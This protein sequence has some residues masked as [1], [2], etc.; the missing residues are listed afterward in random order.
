LVQKLETSERTPGCRAV[1]YDDLFDSRGKQVGR[2]VHVLRI[3]PGQHRQA[4]SA[5][6]EPARIG[7]GVLQEATVQTDRAKV[8]GRESVRGFVAVCHDHELIAL[9]DSGRVG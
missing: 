4:I 5:P 3:D 6:S 9:F 7:E 8:A 1:T 2:T